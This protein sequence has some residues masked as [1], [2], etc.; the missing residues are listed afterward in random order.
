MQTHTHTHQIND[1]WSSLQFNFIVT[2]L[3]KGQFPL[4]KRQNPNVL[5]QPVGE[6]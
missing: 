5:L 4:F 2:A 1:H 6:Y 3:F